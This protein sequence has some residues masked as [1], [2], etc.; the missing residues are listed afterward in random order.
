[1][2]KDIEQ[3]EFVEFCKTRKPVEIVETDYAKFGFGI[4]FDDGTVIQLS[5]GAFYDSTYIEFTK[6]TNP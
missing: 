3:E 6:I 5:T 4:K 1:M 2:E